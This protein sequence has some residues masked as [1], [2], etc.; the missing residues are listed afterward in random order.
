MG[1]TIKR[2]LGEAGNKKEGDC[3]LIYV[4]ACRH[5]GQRPSF[6]P[7]VGERHAN[8]VFK[9]YQRAR[10]ILGLGLVVGCGSHS[11]AQCDGDSSTRVRRSETNTFRGK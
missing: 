11:R 8:P 7:K 6:G 10:L 9:H 4:V 5:A 3:E 1:F 2:D